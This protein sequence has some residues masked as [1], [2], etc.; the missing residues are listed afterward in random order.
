[1]NDL[2]LQYIRFDSAYFKI[3]CMIHRLMQLRLIFA[4]TAYIVDTFCKKAYDYNNVK[5]KIPHEKMFIDETDFCSA[6]LLYLYGID[7]EKRE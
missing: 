3:L 6:S 4:I 1:M 7:G 2:Y 5:K